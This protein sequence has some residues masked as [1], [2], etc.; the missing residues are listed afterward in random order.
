MN[1][2]VTAT[3]AHLKPHESLVERQAWREVVRQTRTFLIHKLGDRSTFVRQEE[4]VAATV[5]E[6][7]C[8]ASEYLLK[9]VARE[10]GELTGVSCGVTVLSSGLDD[11]VYTAQFALYRSRLRLRRKNRLYACI[12]A[13]LA[14]FLSLLIYQEMSGYKL[15]PF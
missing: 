7:H 13:A 10:V 6:Y 2:K 3:N 8:A 11:Q 9:N 12:L 4:T 1:T 14:I 15:L 5:L